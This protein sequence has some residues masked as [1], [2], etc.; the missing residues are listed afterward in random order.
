MCFFFFLLDCGGGCN[1]IFKKKEVN[2]KKLFVDLIACV[3]IF[4]VSLQDTVT[5]TWQGPGA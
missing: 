3:V 4:S 5:W 2:E 1:I